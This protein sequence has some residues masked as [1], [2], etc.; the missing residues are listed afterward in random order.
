MAKK[1]WK[2]YLTEEKEGKKLLGM[3]PKERIYKVGI[4][5]PPKRVAEEFLSLEDASATVSDILDSRGFTN[6]V[7]SA[8]TLNPIKPGQRMAGPAITAHNL[9]DSISVGIGYEKHMLFKHGTDREAYQVAEP[10]DVI[11]LD[12]EGYDISNMGGLSAT[13]AKARG[14]AGNV[15]YGSVRDVETI[16]KTGYP[17]WATGHTPV[18]GKFRYEG[19]AIN[20]PVKLAG[21][22]VNPGDFIVADDSGV[23]V[24]PFDIV[25]EVL[26]EAKK[27]TAIEDDLREFIEK[28]GY[29]I[30]KIMELTKKRYV[31]AVHK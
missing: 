15:I 19:I 21:V 7:I 28:H 9:P 10:G 1:Q 14:C 11:V 17:V 3:M 6:N 22:K 24:I 2:D 31:E 23:A 18:T 8:T 16:R 5:R 13:V 30:E 29:D 26:D 20:V 25:E 12:G 4:R 27:L